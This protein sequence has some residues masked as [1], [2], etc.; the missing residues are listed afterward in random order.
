MKQYSEALKSIL[1]NG[2]KRSDR[3]GEGTISLFGH[4][5]RFDLS[6]GFPAVTTKKLAWKAVVSELLWFIEGSND[7]RRLAEILYGSRDPSKTTIWTENANAPYWKPKASFDG[8]LGRIYGVNWRSWQTAD[9]RTIDQLSSLLERIKKEPYGRRHILSSWNAADVEDANM[10]LPPCHVLAQ[11]YVDEDK[12][13][14]HMYQRS[15]DF[16]LGV[17]FNIASYSLLTHMIAQSCELKVGD[18]IHSFGD[19]HIYLN[20]IEAVKEQL[21]RS[22]YPLPNLKINES[23]KS[24]FD[25][26]MDDF[27]LEGYLCHPPIKAAMA[28]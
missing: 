16:F 23:K 4:Q 22:E 12:L 14:C 13:S 18:F 26:K 24:L 21:T 5:M 7:E 3:T 6:K 15:A 10:A 1:E 9:G 8:D 20:H 27:E 17:P 28:V 25:F 11:F 2:K 19:C